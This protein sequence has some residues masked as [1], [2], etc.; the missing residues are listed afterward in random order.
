M[1]TQQVRGQRSL[2]LS[3]SD[4]RRRRGERFLI[5]SLVHVKFLTFIYVYEVSDLLVSRIG[6][7]DFSFYFFP[8]LT[9]PS[10]RDAL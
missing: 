3:G 9:Y 5:L 8:H 7:P 1:R 6:P 2:C 10:S 4:R